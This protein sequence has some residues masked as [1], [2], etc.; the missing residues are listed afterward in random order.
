[1]HI[2]FFGWRSSCSDPIFG[3][4]CLALWV[5]LIYK[6]YNNE[7][8]K[9]PIIG[10]LAE[11]QRTKT[12][13]RLQ[14]VCPRWKTR[15]AWP[16]RRSRIGFGTRL[17]RKPSV[18]PISLSFY[19][20]ATF[21]ARTTRAQSHGQSQGLITRPPVSHMQAPRIGLIEF[22]GLSKTSEARVRQALGVREGDF[23]PRSKGEAEERIDAVPGIV[24]SHL[25]AVCCDGGNMI[26][27][28]G[29]EE[30]GAKHF[31]LR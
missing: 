20:V 11:K 30:K 8:F 31:D 9:L 17:E 28:I 3:L 25:E 15:Q 12:S 2:P 10:D 23:L 21:F 7:K 26:L 6:A 22:F 5:F 29:V 18:Y 4:V 19:L 16:I 27:F 1:M 13:H 14:P 24:E